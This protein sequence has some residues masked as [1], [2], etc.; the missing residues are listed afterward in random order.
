MSCQRC[1]LLD[2][3]KKIMLKSVHSYINADKETIVSL[4][5]AITKPQSPSKMTS[6]SCDIDPFLADMGSN[7][8]AFES[9]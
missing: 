9:I 2:C 7:T 8:F 3:K 5:I 6:V 4:M 1:I